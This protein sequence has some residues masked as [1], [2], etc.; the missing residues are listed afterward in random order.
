M[1]AIFFAVFALLLANGKNKS[2]EECTNRFCDE[3]WDHTVHF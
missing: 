2:A 1:E 3:F